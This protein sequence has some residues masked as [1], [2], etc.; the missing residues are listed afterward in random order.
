M[1]RALRY[2]CGGNVPA[3][4]LLEFLKGPMMTSPMDGLPVWWC[5]HIHD[6]AM[7]VCAANYGLFSI[8]EMRHLESRKI[9]SAVSI[10]GKEAIAQH[11]RLVFVEGFE[12]KE[13]ILSVDVV[14]K[15]TPAELNQWIQRQSTYFP[16]EETI[17]K[18]MAL[19]ASQFTS[20]HVGVDIDKR[21][22]YYNLPMFDLPT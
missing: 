16:S 11:V 22:V 19:V 8:F 20:P 4:S 18:R 9:Y 17:E 13:P 12:G 2:V 6:L 7:I 10:F 21:M 1:T 3:S 15:L 5:P 14:S